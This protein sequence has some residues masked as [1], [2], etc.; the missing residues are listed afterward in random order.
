MLIA[1][2][3]YDA[4][5]IKQRPITNLDLRAQ[6]GVTYRYFEGTPLWPFGHGMSYGVFNF[7]AS[8][9]ATTLKTTVAKASSVSPQTPSTAAWFPG[10]CVREIA[11]DYSRQE[12]TN[13][14]VSR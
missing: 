5:F 6:G 3:V 1:V 8:S 9:A 7:K 11:R 14:C 2:T 12:S 10:M 4:D 13:R